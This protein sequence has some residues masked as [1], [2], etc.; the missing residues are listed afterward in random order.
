MQNTEWVPNTKEQESNKSTGVYHP[1][2]WPVW[3]GG[4][5]GIYDNEVG[6]TK[7][8]TSLLEELVQV[9]SLALATFFGTLFFNRCSCSC[10]CLSN[11]SGPIHGIRPSLQDL[12][13]IFQV[14][15]PRNWRL[16]LGG[17]HLLSLPMALFHP[18][19]VGRL[20]LRLVLGPNVAHQ[21]PSVFLTLQIASSALSG[22]FGSA[23]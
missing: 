17:N 7:I 14:L 18:T 23:P 10:C 15:R 3:E 19:F 20:D 6:F 5:T 16:L 12:C 21:L 11:I 2:S 13:L 1:S 9:K 8:E 4:A 22:P